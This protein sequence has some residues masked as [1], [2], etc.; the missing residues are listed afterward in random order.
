MNRNSGSL[1]LCLSI[2]RNNISEEK[3]ISSNGINV[4]NKYSVEKMGVLLR[5]QKFW[6]TVFPN[7]FAL[8]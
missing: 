1:I 2:I 6:Y 5:R 8:Y 3:K 4:S 7:I